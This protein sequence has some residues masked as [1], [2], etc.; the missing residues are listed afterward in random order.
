MANRN[1][2]RP[3]RIPNAILEG[4]RIGFR[5]FAGAEDQYNREGDRNFAVFLDDERIAA[6]LS[7]DGWNVK[8]TKDKPEIEGYEPIWYI[9][10]KVSYKIRAPKVMLVT[11]RGKTPIGEGE[12]SMLDWVE[13]T[14]VDLIL[15]AN[16]WAMNG[17]KGY[18]AYLQSM[19]IT[20]IEDELDEKYGDIP[21][22]GGGQQMVHFEEE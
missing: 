6:Q 14:N 7:E 10:V 17:N 22:L 4:V 12:I 3:P 20:I 18:T 16:P 21:T 5:N 19:F 8:R 15:N 13:Y 11:K 2:D 1:D 9:P